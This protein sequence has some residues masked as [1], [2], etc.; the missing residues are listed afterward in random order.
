MKWT[1]RN[2]FH[3]GDER[4]EEK[5]LIKRV[6]DDMW[7][8]VEDYIGLLFQ[9]YEVDKA[10]VV[11]NRK[12]IRQLARKLSS[13]GR[14]VIDY[15]AARFTAKTHVATVNKEVNKAIDKKVFLLTYLF[16]ERD[17]DKVLS[18]F[19]KDLNLS[20]KVSNELYL[21]LPE[22]TPLDNKRIELFTYHTIIKVEAEQNYRLWLT[23]QEIKD[24][25]VSEFGIPLFQAGRSVDE[26]MPII[27]DSEYLKEV[28]P[29]AVVMRG[30]R[31]FTGKELYENMWAF[32]ESIGRIQ[33]NRDDEE[34]CRDEI[35]EVNWIIRNK[36]EKELGFE[37]SSEQ[38]RAVQAFWQSNVFILTGEAGSGKTTTINAIID[39]LRELRPESTIFGAS[40]TARAS[41]NL[42]TVTKLKDNEWGTLHKL[43]AT[44]K[45]LQEKP[46]QD[47]LPLYD[48][49]DVLI[50]EEFSM[51]SLELI[52]EIMPH[53]KDSVKILMIGDVEQLPPIQIGYA[54][55]FMASKI[56][57]W[58][59]L[60]EIQRQDKEGVLYQFINGVRKE[61]LNERL[62]DNAQRNIYDD[63]V[64]I[65]EA[66]SPIK[67]VDKAMR[68]YMRAIMDDDKK[69]T[70]AD[71]QEGV[72][73]LA[74]TN[75]IVDNCNYE[76]QKK[77]FEY[78]ELLET[79]YHY[80]L[81]GESFYVGDRVVAKK[82]I[83]GTAI[84]NGMTGRIVEIETKRHVTLKHSLFLEPETEEDSIEIDIPIIERVIVDFDDLEQPIGLSGYDELGYLKLGYATTIHK[85]Q[86]MTLNTAI[87][88]FS[89]ENYMNSRQLLYTAISRP[90]QKL[91]LIS[92]NY[93]LQRSIEKNVY[94]DARYLYQD[95]LQHTTY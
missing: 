21:A 26:L 57:Q 16:E 92:S 68:E 36:T 40:F 65:P 34:K 95:V 46:A 2:F 28:K 72:R 29:P 58:I 71:L 39:C 5:R 7:D 25:L 94:A 70:R 87:V 91:V 83:P 55:D 20:W 14:E 64:Y 27:Y 66:S 45:W 60:E 89:R 23:E 47:R 38:I 52:S 53:L 81:N 3:Q 9:N 50:V 42:A 51:V 85:A 33:V 79:D 67:V 76:I 35:A 49:I 62:L 41:F 19:L 43:I 6:T 44:N 78:S 56:S 15:E 59:E 63:F 10:W 24:S 77:L 80:K 18:Y 13:G 88:A 73:V 86:G 74:T 75:K 22:T 31:A 90:R 12:Q 93:V 48:E 82:N 11:D 4:L 61:T 37:L 84:A 17:W 69:F 30:E 32:F 1:D 8:M 54:Y